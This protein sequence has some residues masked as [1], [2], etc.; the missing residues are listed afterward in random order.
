MDKHDSITVT[1]IKAIHALLNRAGLMD[2]KKDLVRMY[3][4]GNTESVKNM[5]YHEA[6]E[7]LSHLNSFVPPPE[8]TKE[9]RDGDRM[10][11]RLI[12]MAHELRWHKQGSLK[13]DINRIDR[14]CI[15]YGYLHKRF[16]EY[17]NKELP[18]LITQFEN[19]YVQHL[20]RK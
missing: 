14:W 8:L 7:L 13:I 20:S 11:K 3:S 10:R 4:G 1:Q 2:D 16:Q 18:G 12:S 15:K 9:Q 19:M 5:M 17:S 6:R